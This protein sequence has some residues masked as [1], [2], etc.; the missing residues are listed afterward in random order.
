MK[1]TLTRDHVRENESLYE[2]DFYAWTR[3]TAAQLRQRQ[4]DAIDLDH[5]A[6][7]IEDMGKRDAKELDSRMHVLIA[8]LLEWQVQPS[9]RSRSWVKTIGTQRIEI[10]IVLDQSPSLRRR[11]GTVLPKNYS[12]AVT[13][14]MLDTGLSCDQF[15]RQC[16]YTLAQV[17]DDGFLPE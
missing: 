7:E 1:A 2:T 14:A 3:L 4:L 10:G 11:L 12:R 17:L 6:E 8:H 9:K 5:A 15:P 16:P 13:R